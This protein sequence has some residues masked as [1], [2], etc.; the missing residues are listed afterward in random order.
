MKLSAAFSALA[1]A[2][3]ARAA[4][5]AD[6]DRCTVARA[7]AD[8]LR[9]D[10]QPWI[11]QLFS[12]CVGPASNFWSTKTC[13]AAAIA[14]GPRTIVDFATCDKASTPDQASQPD[15]DE[16]LYGEIGDITPQK[17]LDLV[18]GELSAINASIWPESGDEIL[19]DVIGPVFTWAGES[20][21][22]YERFNKW[23]HDSG[24]ISIITDDEHTSGKTYYYDHEDDK[25]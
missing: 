21:I 25:P 3:T 16:S 10:Y 13:I 19:E 17:L 6:Y 5:S 4:P 14:M 22:S 18:Y 11:E 20:P 9:D 8:G 12:P 2:L 23:L 24:Y 7:Q 1:L 15:L